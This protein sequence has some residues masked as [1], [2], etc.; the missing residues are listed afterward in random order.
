MARALK[1]SGRRPNLLIGCSAVYLV[2]LAG[3]TL[4]NRCGADLFWPGALNLYLPQA[5]WALPG[6]LLAGFCLLR[7][8]RWCWLPLSGV[9]WVA[10]PLMGLCSPWPGGHGTQ[11]GLPLRVMTWNV[12]Y[13]GSDRLAQLALRQEIDRNAPALVLFQDASGLWDGPL[14]QY[15]R[16]WNVRSSGQYLVA[17]R[18]PLGELQTLPI[19]FPGE[20]QTL[21]RTELL[22]GPFKVALYNVHFQSPR[23]GLN[24]LR[25]VPGNPDLLPVALRQLQANVARLSQAGT[26]RAYLSRERGPVIVAG[27][28]N[29]T[30]SS[31]VLTLLEESGLHDAF[32]Q[33][34]RGYGYSYGHFLLQHRL[35]AWNFSWMRIDHI[36][37][38][39]QLAA[40]SCWA[41]TSRASAHRPVIADLRLF[42]D[43]CNPAGLLR[44]AARR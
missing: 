2:L 26:L 14:A 3:L 41:G 44:T 13:S 25:G 27:D 43:R 32:S 34:G 36:M 42:P 5:L 38:S 37:M 7:A 40:R 17:S 6:V 10:G 15:F 20:E 11:G 16:N 19:A 30:E 21:V 22:V 24:A 29:S 33:A 9:A 31:R 23:G 1:S 28:L 39:R 12:K 18:L 8:P 4:L 35:P